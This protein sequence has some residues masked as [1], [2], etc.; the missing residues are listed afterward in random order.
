M[1]RYRGALYPGR[2]YPGRCPGLGY[3]ALAGRK[4]LA[5]FCRDA[6]P[7][8]S[9]GDRKGRPYGIAP[10]AVRHNMLVENNDPL[11]PPPVPSG[12]EPVVALRQS[13]V[14]PRQSE[15]GFSQQRRETYGFRP[16][17][18]VPDGTGAE[19]GVRWFYQHVVPSGTRWTRHVYTY[20]YRASAATTNARLEPCPLSDVGWSLRRAGWI[21]YRRSMTYGYEDQALQAIAMHREDAGRRPI[22]ITPCKRSAA[23]G[24]ADLFSST[25]KRVEL[26]RSSRR[27][28]CGTPSCAALARGYPY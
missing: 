14:A 2:C 8:G 7:C 19:G 13:E 21:S 20:I 15:I 25:P 1:P 17:G 28:G 18:S 11:P 27:R 26:L 24:C 3:V 16:S 4:R 12:T 6:R 10:C 9:T 23:R 5:A 22:W